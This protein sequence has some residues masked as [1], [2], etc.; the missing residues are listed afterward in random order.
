MEIFLLKKHAIGYINKCNNTNIHLF[1]EDCSETNQSKRFI[2]TTYDKI[3]NLIQTGRNN[4]YESWLEDTPLY[5]GV[6]ISFMRLKIIGT[7]SGYKICQ[8]N[9]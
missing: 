2:V 9:F 8:W 6:D 5:F 1:Q 3:Y 7:I 4:F